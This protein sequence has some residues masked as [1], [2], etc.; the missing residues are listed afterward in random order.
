MICSAGG[1][2]VVAGGA[3]VQA[4][5]IHISIGDDEQGILRIFFQI[6]LQVFIEVLPDVGAGIGSTVIADHCFFVD[7][8]QK[9]C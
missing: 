8:R 7:L 2:T 3:P 6:V 1:I 5:K 9:R 4:F